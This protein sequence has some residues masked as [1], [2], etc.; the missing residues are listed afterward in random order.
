MPAM[1]QTIQDIR[2]E[3]LNTKIIVG[4]AP[5]SQEYADKIGAD[6]YSEDAPGCVELVKKIMA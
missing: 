2:S 3:G 1:A 4:G 6:G 5:I